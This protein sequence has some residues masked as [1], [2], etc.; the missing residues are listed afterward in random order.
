MTTTQSMSLEA[1]AAVLAAKGYHP[2]EAKLR[3][4]YAAL[5]TIEA[6]QQRVRHGTAD[7]A[8]EPSHIFVEPSVTAIAEASE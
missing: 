1:F 5:H 6:L 3:S 8:L 7:I 2:D 4:L